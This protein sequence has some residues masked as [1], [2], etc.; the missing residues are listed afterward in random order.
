MLLVHDDQAEPVERREHRRS[1]A[2]NQVHGALPHAVPLIVAL[3]VGETAV[4]NRHAMRRTRRG[5]DPT[6]C[7]V[8]AISG[9]RI[10]TRRPAAM[11][12]AASRRYSSVF[13]LPVT[14]CSSAV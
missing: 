12:C 8:S 14:P 9:T 3:A 2:D 10:S 4:L 13:P 7:G 6:T 5:P 11:A 1:R